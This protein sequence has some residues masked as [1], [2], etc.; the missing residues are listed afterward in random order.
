MKLLVVDLD[1][2]L[3]DGIL[4]ETPDRAFRLRDGV[5][6]ALAEL[7]RRGILL[8]IASKNNAD[9]ARTVLQ[10]M[11]I[12]DLFLHPQI[13]W[14]PKSVGIRRT[15]EALNIGM[16]SVAFIDDSEFEL[17]EVAAALPAVRTFRANEFASLPSR[18][19]FDAPVTDESRGRRSLYRQEQNRQAEYRQSHLDYDAFLA[20]CGI[21]LVMEAL[22]SSNSER[23]YELVQR[24][25]QLNYS[26]T[27][28]TRPDLDGL[29]RGK[30]IVPVVMRCEDRFG[31]YGIVGFSILRRRPEA[32]EIAD[33]MFSCRIQGK[34]IEHSYFAFLIEAAT[35]GGAARVICRF[36]RTERNAPAARVFDD[37]G[38]EKIEAEGAS[39]TWCIDGRTFQ[40]RPVPAQ[41]TDAMDLAARLAGPEQAG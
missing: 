17:G 16:D 39:E 1:N 2:T 35:Q 20:S 36:K 11:G 8:S 6:E 29:L 37:L 34:K 19:E 4:L 3:W 18:S 25:N 9:E 33:L 21:R 32:L 23:V 24:T 30:G 27:R 13:N 40:R 5:G 38:F 7:D 15:V 12:W 31:T 10:N 26:G 28:Y 14:D 41:V 22:N